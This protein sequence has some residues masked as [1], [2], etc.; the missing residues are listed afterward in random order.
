[1]RREACCTTTTA[2]D[3]QRLTAEARDLI[4]QRAMEL[5]EHSAA[6]ALANN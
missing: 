3:A 4:V 6:S 1:M 2:A 5:G